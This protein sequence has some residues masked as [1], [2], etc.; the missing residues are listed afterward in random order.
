MMTI[1]WYRYRYTYIRYKYVYYVYGGLAF[2]ILFRSFHSYRIT[3]E[4]ILEKKVLRERN[5]RHR[6]WL[7]R[8]SILFH[9][10]DGF[11]TSI[12]DDV[13]V[14]PKMEYNVHPCFLFNTIY[15]ILLGKV[16]GFFTQSIYFIYYV[17][18]HTHEVFMFCF[19]S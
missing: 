17:S 14:P 7:K 2:S 1:I 9:T 5:I 15:L 12:C 19:L 13:V 3:E 10:T 11:M 6:F 4:M 18:K 8:K 16:E